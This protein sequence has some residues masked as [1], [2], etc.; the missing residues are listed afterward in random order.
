MVDDTENKPAPEK[1]VH[2]GSANLI[3]IKPGEIRNP[4]G[5]R[6]GTKNRRTY[7]LQALENA[8]AAKALEEQRRTLGEEHRP[9]TIMDQITARLVI[10]ALAG[11]KAATAILLDGAFGKEP[12]KQEIKSNFG[13]LLASARTPAGELPKVSKGDECTDTPTSKPPAS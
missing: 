8:A 6:P 10:D 13:A 4:A 9:E 2:K 1:P 11:D 5:K 12:E 7:F 3:P